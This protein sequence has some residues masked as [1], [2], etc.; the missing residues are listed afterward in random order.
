MLARP[1]ERAKIF[2]SLLLDV[3]EAMVGDRVR[4]FATAIVKV[5]YRASSVNTDMENELINLIVL[6]DF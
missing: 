4:V 3:I 1:I 5:V 2:F 6:R